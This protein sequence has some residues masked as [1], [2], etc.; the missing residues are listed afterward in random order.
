MYSLH[1]FFSLFF[2]STGYAIAACMLLKN[3]RFVV[4]SAAD[5]LP[6]FSLFLIYSRVTL[7]NLFSRYMDE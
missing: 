3:V 6:R 5:F 2:I 4:S 1:L 7:F